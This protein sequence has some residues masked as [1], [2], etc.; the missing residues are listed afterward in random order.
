MLTKRVKKL[1][2]EARR[3]KGQ[4]YCLVYENDDTGRMSIE[5]NYEEVFKGTIEKGEQVLKKLDE[6]NDL[7]AIIRLPDF[8]GRTN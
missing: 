4:L 2:Q 3:K 7:A 6:E 8:S 1:E 5:L